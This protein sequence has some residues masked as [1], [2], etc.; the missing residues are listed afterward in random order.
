MKIKFLLC[1]PWFALSLAAAA[2]HAPENFSATNALVLTPALIRGWT[3]EL[4]TNHPALLSARAQVT[5][6][7]AS[8]AAV[9]TWEDPTIKL[10]GVAAREDFRASDG[11]IFY[12]VEQKLPLFG[13]P[14]L[15]RQIAAA[16]LAVET[17]NADF[18]FQNVRREFSQA[19]FKAALASE[20]VTV[21]EEDFVWL[22]AMTQTLESKY[23][24][25][26]SRLAEVLSLQNEQAKR[27]EQLVTERQ[28]LIHLQVGLNR[29]LNRSFHS[30]W[31]KLELPAVAD[32]VEYNDALV[33]RALAHEPKL[34]MMRAQIQQAK[35][36]VA[37]T[38]RQR[39]PEVSAGIQSRNYSGNGN[40]RQAEF[41]VSFNL[42]LGNA[43]KYRSDIRRDEAKR[44]ATEFE[45][46]DYELTV[47]EDLHMMTVNLDAAR[48]TARRY[49]DE[50]L[51]RSEQ[52][53]SAARTAWE[54][55][56]GQ[57]RDVLDARRML[58]DSRLAYAGAV[59]EQ[60]RMLGELAFACGDETAD[61]QTK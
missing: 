13:K 30:P 61:F 4:R 24:T 6:A 57:F 28:K 31:P 53:V 32:A 56:G 12:G 8:V 59:T 34:K 16:G 2:E 10:G 41:M 39:L 54:T 22:A 58:L 27:G 18:L 49:R 29:F 14:R 52:A 46:A 51:P 19:L 9:R 25:G 11:D 45:V 1:L 23:S 50:I 20:T 44:A 40:F 43:D 37:L 55:G 42:P 21:G 38:R 33:A 35:A 60:Q 36:T 48:R 7:A 3:E 5:A 15:A 17:N 47:R 26:Q